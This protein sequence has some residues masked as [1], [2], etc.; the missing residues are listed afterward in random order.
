VLADALTSIFAIAALLAGKYL[1]WNWLDPV[2]GM[3]GAMMISKWAYSL[4]KST[5]SILLDESIGVEQQKEIRQ[6][7]EQAQG[8][9]VDLHIWQVGTNSYAL[10]ASVISHQTPMPD[11]YRQLLKAYPRITHI[12]VE[13]IP[14][15]DGQTC[16][17][18]AV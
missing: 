1:S 5:G 14:C 4:T 16:E 9:V 12:T 17:A 8:R 6:L 2:M 10:M 13:T 15:E 18:L 7:L 3:V 11:Y